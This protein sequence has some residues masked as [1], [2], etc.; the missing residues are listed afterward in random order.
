[1]DDFA[2]RCVDVI[3]HQVDTYREIFFTDSI[4]INNEPIAISVIMEH[5]D[6]APKGQ[7]ANAETPTWWSQNNPMEVAEGW[8]PNECLITIF[9]TLPVPGN[10]RFDLKRAFL[11]Q[12]LW[13]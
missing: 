13:G 4:V 9:D 7:L 5:P 11:R 12:R 6:K 8:M 3:M 1:M 10:H 2:E